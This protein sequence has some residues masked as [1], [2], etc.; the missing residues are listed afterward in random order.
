VPS[1]PPLPFSLHLPP[2]LF[3]LLSPS[4][5]CPTLSS[6]FLLPCSP[7]LCLPPPPSA[8]PLLFP[9]S[10]LLPSFLGPA[11]LASSLCLLPP[12][13]PISL[14]PPLS[15]PA[16]LPLPLFL[17]LHPPSVSWPQR[18]T[19]I[20][21][22]VSLALSHLSWKHCGSG[23]GLFPP[24]YLSCLQLPSWETKLPPE[25]LGW[26]RLSLQDWSWRMCVCVC[27]CVQQTTNWK[28]PGLAKDPRCSACSS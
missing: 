11:R 24:L 8:Y 4:Y 26:E 12:L 20:G 1:C 16:L 19:L 17:G 28:P 18:S 15:L 13:F 5:L 7:S 22:L 2:F 9:P 3:L 25:L 23:V 6:L 27:V 10:A 21:L 14:P